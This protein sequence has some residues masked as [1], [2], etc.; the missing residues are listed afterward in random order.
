MVNILQDRDNLVNYLDI[1]KLIVGLMSTVWL[2]VCVIGKIHV[3]NV[4]LY[5]TAHRNVINV[6]RN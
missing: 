4:F 3:L 5:T 6:I 2:D 1:L